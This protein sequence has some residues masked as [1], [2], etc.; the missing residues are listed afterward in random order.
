MNETDLS[1]VDPIFGGWPPIVK[2]WHK[3]D[4]RA[5]FRGQVHGSEI[6]TQAPEPWFNFENV[7]AVMVRNGV[8]IPWKFDHTGANQML[9]MDYGGFSKAASVRAR[10]MAR[11]GWQR[12]Y[13]T[14]WLY[15]PGFE[16]K[17][18]AVNIESE[19][20]PEPLPPRII[21][22][23]KFTYTDIEKRMNAAHA[24]YAKIEYRLCQDTDASDD[25]RRRVWRQLA[26]LRA[27]YKALTAEYTA[28]EGT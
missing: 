22:A 12:A 19:P 9:L 21:R 28:Q 1:I 18:Q 16:G 3:I 7:L 2:A 13:A 24:R 10:Q 8:L 4:Q 14:L 23:P 17:P 11:G 26:K 5:V 25:K 15:R 20:E 27:E 6:I